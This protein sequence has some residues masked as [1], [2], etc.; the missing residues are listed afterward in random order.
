MRFRFSNIPIALLAI[1]GVAS[2]I[3]G[4]RDGGRDRWTVAKE[5]LETRC[6]AWHVDHPL[7]TADPCR[8][9]GPYTKLMPIYREAQ[10]HLMVA[11]FRVR[12]ANDTTAMYLGFALDRATEMDREGSLLGSILAAKVFE[13]A[14]DFIDKERNELGKERIAILLEGRSLTTAKHPFEGERLA[15]ETNMAAIPKKLP[16]PTGPFGRALAAQAMNEHDETLDAMDRAVSARDLEGCKR[17][18]KERPH[19]LY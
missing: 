12:L 7:A 16:V 18:A 8:P 1:I 15:I 5:R 19:A 17:V 9:D 10:D 6:E 4:A 14:L 13:D 3:K 2:M 11:R